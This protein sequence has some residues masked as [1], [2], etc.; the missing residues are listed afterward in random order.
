MAGRRP[1]PLP[2]GA[3]LLRA[4]TPIPAWLLQ[5]P[6]LSDLRA[7]PGLLFRT[8]ARTAGLRAAAGPFEHRLIDISAT[9][10]RPA[11]RRHRSTPV[12][13]SETASGCGYW[14]TPSRAAVQRPCWRCLRRPRPGRP[15]PASA[16]YLAPAAA[17][18][19][20]AIDCSAYDLDP[21]GAGPAAHLSAV[22]TEALLAAGGWPPAVNARRPAWRRGLPAPHHPAALT[23]PRLPARTLFRRAAAALPRR[24]SASLLRR[25][26]MIQGRGPPRYPRHPADLAAARWAFKGRY[27]EAAQL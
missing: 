18:L 14:P 7:V 20:R 5:L 3:V 10:P 12:V 6:P 8:M 1:R 24:S 22:G 23:A 15:G 17:H 11:V 13:A 26:I 19:K 9:A 16:G 27:G 4:A 21:A 2:A 25:R